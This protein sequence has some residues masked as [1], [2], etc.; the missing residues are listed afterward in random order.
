MPS[1]TNLS[2]LRRLFDLELNFF[3]LG[4]KG[5]FSVKIL[6]LR[7]DLFLHPE[8]RPSCIPCGQSGFYSFAEVL[9]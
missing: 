9:P 2:V 6:P 1:T 4:F 3:F 8:Y 5:G 7:S